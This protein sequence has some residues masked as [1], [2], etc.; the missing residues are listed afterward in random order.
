MNYTLH[1]LQVFVKV[2]QNLS[3]TKAS[4][5]LFMTQPAVSI[6][7]KKFQDQFEIPLTEVIK[8]RLRVTDFGMEIYKMSERILSEVY[9]INYKTAAYKG[10]LSGRL[11][12][13]VVSTG[14]YV[15]PYFLSGF[16]RKHTG[17]E[18]IMD[19]TNKARVIES[20]SL[21]EIDFALVSILPDKVPVSEEVL[22]D[23][24]LYF[25]ANKDFE[26]SKS[27]L[28]KEELEKYALI[29]REEGSATR[30]VMEEYFERK[31]LHAR[32]KIELTSN[33]A[34]KQAV[35][36]GLGISIMPMIGIREE[37]KARRMKIIP[38]AGLPIKTK[39]RLI[40]LKEKPLTPVA[41]EYLD[42]LRDTKAE[43]V[44]RNF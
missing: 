33:E 30:K 18:L 21:G 10:L 24:E 5:E 7:L 34:V 28:S 4:E 41:K 42:Y 2:V 14:K 32:K 29:Y 25:V 23:N 26:L 6:Q 3:I 35:L 20:L 37:V 1:Q 31:N 38:A 44:K 16:I 40:W 19:V 11:S 43:L 17:V 8:K 12:F 9:A 22:M 27:R 15:M 13:G 39:W 36:A